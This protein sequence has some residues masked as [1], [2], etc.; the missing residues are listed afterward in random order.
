LLTLALNFDILRAHTEHNINTSHMRTKTLA[1]TAALTAAG[2]LT[3]MAQ[4]YS[5]NI[6]GYINLNVPQGFSMIANQLNATPDNTLETLLPA[7]PEGTII[8]KFNPALRGGLG[9]YDQYQFSADNP[10]WLPITG[11]SPA[12]TTL[13]PGEGAFAGLPSAAAVTFVGEVQ[14]VSHNPVNTGFQIISS[15]IPQNDTLDNLGFPATEGDIAYF[16]DPTLRGGLGAYNQYQWSAD[17]P[18]WMAIT[19]N[20]PSLQPTPKVGESFF[21][22]SGNAGR[23]WDRT[24]TVGP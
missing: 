22:A 9:A 13:N 12:H 19:A 16:F 23:T 10:G 11:G 18:G 24:F 5:V 3:S 15:V 7:P 4:V 21:F 8:Y 1:L 6:V 17:N 20:P 2:A 14:L